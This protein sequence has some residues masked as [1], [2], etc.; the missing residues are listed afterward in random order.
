M[1]QDEHYMQLAINEAL[2]ANNLVASNPYVGAVIVAD[3]KIISR[4]Y[5]HLYGGDH[6]EIDA[7][8]KLDCKAKGAT[9]YVTLEPC[10]HYGKTKPC[11]EAIINACITRVVIGSV[12]PNPLVSGKSI[13]RLIDANIDV[14]EGILK[15]ECDNLNRDFFKFITSQRPYVIMKSAMTLDGKIATSNGDSYGISSDAANRY[16]H[17]LRNKTQA[18]AVGV[19]TVIADN[20]RLTCRLEGGNDPIRIIFDSCLKTPIDSFIVQSANR[21]QTIIVT[22]NTD[23]NLHAKYQ[24]HDVKLVIAKCLQKRI[25]LNDAMHKLAKLKIKSILLEAGSTLAYAMLE[26]QFVDQLKIY[27]APKI[28]GGENSFSVVGGLGKLAVKDA[29]NLEFETIEFLGEDILVSAKMKRG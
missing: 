15:K 5:H 26:H 9:I 24:K 16:T 8:N 2:K 11:V 14:T 17:E 4:G 6:A 27:I 19:N 18:I 7:L 3:G 22:T 25:D 1:K 28:I 12:D 29:I 13:K 20:P 21:I 10:A 23:L